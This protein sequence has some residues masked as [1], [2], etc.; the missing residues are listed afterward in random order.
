VP[1]R[2]RDA[3]RARQPDQRSA[4]R[5]APHRADRPASQAALPARARGA[6]PHGAAPP[7]SAPSR[8]AKALS[9]SSAPAVGR[10]QVAAS[11]VS[12]VRGRP[13][14]PSS[15][16]LLR[17]DE[18]DEHPASHGDVGPGFPGDASHGARRR[19]RW[20]PKPCGRPVSCSAALQRSR[21]RQRVTAL[22]LTPLP[23][24]RP[25]RE[26]YS[27]EQGLRKQ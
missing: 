27:R 9:Q 19:V 12:K 4:Y 1:Q 18:L 20:Q 8:A 17:P 5:G 24:A 10:S 7:S 23:N 3:L 2:L 11:S 16:E 21:R 6:N 15:N 26:S 25:H 22:Q 13:S 14:Q